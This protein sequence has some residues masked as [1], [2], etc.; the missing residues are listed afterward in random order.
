M[1]Q[2]PSRLFRLNSIVLFE[3]R[4][5]RIPKELPT[6]IPA[7]GLCAQSVGHRELISR[8]GG[9]PEPEEEEVEGMARAC[10]NIE[11]AV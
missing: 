10:T 4:V 8:G 5:D 3:L 2:S 1:V 7:L 6:L 9:L 11:S